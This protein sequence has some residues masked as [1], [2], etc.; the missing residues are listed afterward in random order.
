[1]TNSFSKKTKIV[2]AFLFL[3]IISAFISVFYYNQGFGRFTREIVITDAD[4][5]KGKSKNDVNE[6]VITDGDLVDYKEVIA[7]SEESRVGEVRKLGD[8]SEVSTMFDGYGNKT[9]TRQFQDHSRIKKIV[10]RINATGAGRIFVYGQN[11]VVENLPEKMANNVLNSSADELANL[12]NIYETREQRDR[13]I[14]EKAQR[15]RDELKP[16]PSSENPINN[17]NVEFPKETPPK[18]ADDKETEN[19]EEKPTKKGQ[20]KDS[21][22]DLELID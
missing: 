6:L 7:T 4:F 12:A 20:G 14:L 5:E 2:S 8:N 16:K 9:L 11:G 18:G 19:S 15:K 13:K 10:L 1:M 21:E 3:F 22:E 17:E